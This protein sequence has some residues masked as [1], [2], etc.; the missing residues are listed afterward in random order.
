MRDEGFGT[1][2][3]ASIGEGGLK[4][5][6]IDLPP[7]WIICEV[8]DLISKGVQLEFKRESMTHKALDD[9]MKL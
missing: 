3:D 8:E 9:P 7:P 2:H 4:Y 5:V 6:L 1:S